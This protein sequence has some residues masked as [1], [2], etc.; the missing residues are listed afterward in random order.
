[1]LKHELMVKTDNWEPFLQ[2][3]DACE[4]YLLYLFLWKL[5]DETIV[6][7]IIQLSG[8]SNR[9]L[10]VSKVAVTETQLSNIEKKLL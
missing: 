6:V 9:Q 5:Q 2:T 4:V 1:M 10:M 7:R 8:P 3:V